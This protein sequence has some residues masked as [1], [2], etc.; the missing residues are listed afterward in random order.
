MAA[1]QQRVAAAAEQHTADALVIHNL[2]TAVQQYAHAPIGVAQAR[3][4]GPRPAP[5][6]TY[7]GSKGQEEWK[8]ALKQQD[9]W[10]RLVRD[11]DRIHFAEGYL[12]GP[13]LA[14]SDTAAGRIATATTWAVFEAAL[15]ARFQPVT[16]AEIARAKI[17]T[18][19]QG[20][21]TVHEYTSE[22]N[23][24]LVSLPDQDD[25]TT[26]FHYLRGV[27]KETRELIR[28]AGTTVLLEAQTAAMRIGNPMPIMSIV[29]TSAPM[30]LSALDDEP[31]TERQAFVDMLADDVLA[32]IQSR[33]SVRSHGSG[34][35]A[36]KG[37]GSNGP[38]PWQSRFPSHDGLT[39]DQIKALMDE[40]KCFSCGKQG[41][42]RGNCPKTR[43]SSSS[44]RWAGK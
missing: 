13:A 21:A 5:M 19:M 30:D 12:A 20:K 15:V 31:C 35:G 36:A 11:E 38:C 42:Q 26:L 37:A 7:D 9:R 6:T 4:G 43:A 34:V 14:W 27:K 10:Y 2:Q 33:Q 25:A 16:S 41:H 24:L 32:A 44:A 28:A 29:S 22:F 17:C 8:L 3:P 1:L 23:R 39:R 18:L 40:G